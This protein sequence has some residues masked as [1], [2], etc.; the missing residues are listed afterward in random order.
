MLG[1]KSQ[2]MYEFVLVKLIV[3][4]GRGSLV[5]VNA[6][7]FFFFDKST[8]IEVANALVMVQL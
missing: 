1:K 3:E 8:V 4:F 7:F 5:I 6:F 2:K